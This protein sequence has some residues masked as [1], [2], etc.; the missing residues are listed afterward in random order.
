MLILFDKVLYCI[1]TRIILQVDYM[2]NQ[3]YYILYRT[4]EKYYA[5]LC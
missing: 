3:Y 5:F 4:F 2:V 1:K